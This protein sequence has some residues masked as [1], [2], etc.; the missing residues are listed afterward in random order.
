MSKD[1]SICVTLTSPI[2][3]CGVGEKDVECGVGDK[4]VDPFE[5]KKSAD[6]SAKCSQTN[7]PRLYLHVVQNIP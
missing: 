1:E 4:D 3:E 5:A 6:K 7:W 2:I